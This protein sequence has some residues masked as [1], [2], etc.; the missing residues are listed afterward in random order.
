MAEARQSEIQ[1]K[2]KSIELDMKQQIEH[3]WHSYRSS[4]Q[5]I[6][7]YK[8]TISSKSLK[9]EQLSLE[10]YR[11]GEIDLLNLINAQQTY[12]A[13]QKRFLTAL[14][15]YYL[16]LAQLEKFLNKDLVY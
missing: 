12:L 14:R 9:L 13:N 6:D 1:W 15:D 4:K 16:Q 8:M 3:A 11:L 7:R 10:A 2:Q 5:I